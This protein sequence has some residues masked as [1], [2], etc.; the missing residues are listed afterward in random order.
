[1]YCRIYG[2][3]YLMFT[4]FPTLFSGIYGWGPGV[5]GLA[6][7][8]PGIGFLVATMVGSRLLLKTYTV[9]RNT[10]T[11]DRIELITLCSYANATA[12]RESLNSVSPPC[13]W[14]A[15]SYLLVF[16]GTDGPLKHARTGFC[17]SSAQVFSCATYSLSPGSPH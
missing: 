17:P 13:S 3:L 15:S 2:Y 9:V 5:S 1:M 16:S 11:Q 14:E 7:L 6:Y 8:G 12:A 4:T 10:S